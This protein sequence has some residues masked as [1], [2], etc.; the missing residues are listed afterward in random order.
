MNQQTTPSPTYRWV[1]ASERLP[2]DIS[3]VKWLR[4]SDMLLV[5]AVSVTV[6]FIWKE[7]R[8]YIEGTEFSQPLWHYEWMEELPSPSEETTPLQIESAEEVLKKYSHSKHIA[9]VTGEA[10]YEKETVVEAME[11][12]ANQKANDRWIC[13]DDEL[14][15]NTNQILLFEGLILAGYYL[16]TAKMMYDVNGVKLHNITHWQPLPNKPL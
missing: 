14:P 12:Y 5:K 13:V 16:P 11:E 1:K 7:R 2:E 4:L 15:K 6:P 9:E 3:K 10:W 8:I